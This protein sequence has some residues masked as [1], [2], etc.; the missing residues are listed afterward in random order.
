MPPRPSSKYAGSMTS[1]CAATVARLAGATPGASEQPDTRDSTR[2][3]AAVAGQELVTWV[4][5]LVTRYEL[6]NIPECWTKHG[7]LVEEL[8]ALRIGW[9]DTIGKGQRGLAATQWHDYFSRALER[10]DRRWR[11]LNCEDAHRD[12][13]LPGWVTKDP[14]RPGP[15]DL[16]TGRHRSRQG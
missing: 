10:F 16:D 3:D 5:W 1:S 4:Q 6:N 8:D 9:L 13:T 14:A 7:A 12:T 2:R 11:A 15:P